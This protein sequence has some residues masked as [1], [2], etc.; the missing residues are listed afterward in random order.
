MINFGIFK[1]TKKIFFIFYPAVENTVVSYLM[2][3]LVT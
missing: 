1:A 3:V 2:I